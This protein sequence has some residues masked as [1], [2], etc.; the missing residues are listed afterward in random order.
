MSSRI[1]D[2]VQLLREIPLFSQLAPDELSALAEVTVPREFPKRALVFDEGDPGDA[3]F[4]IRSGVVRIYR[5]DREGREQTLAF[6]EAGAWFGEMAIFDG[7]PRSAAAECLTSVKLLAVAREDF[8]RVVR[9]HPDIAI[10]LLEAM[11]L[12][13]RRVNEQVERVAFWDARTRIAA[14]LLDLARD[15]GKAAPGGIALTLRL[16][17]RELAAYAGTS[18]E[19]VSRVLGD[20]YDDGII[21]VGARGIVIRSPEKLAE[22]AEN[23]SW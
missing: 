1:E 3:V 12:R 11:S 4:L 17:H 15:H 20:L 23:Q 13:L 2:A 22:Q 19:T 10:H 5:L 21:E 14:A 6:L 16:T 8:I 18:R 9:A 7:L